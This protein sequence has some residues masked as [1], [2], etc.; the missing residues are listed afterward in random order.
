MRRRSPSS[1]PSLGGLHA[2][3][4]QRGHLQCDDVELGARGAEMEQR[5]GKGGRIVG[6]VDEDNDEAVAERSRV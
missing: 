5:V 2:I 6:R 3:R 4:E 1:R